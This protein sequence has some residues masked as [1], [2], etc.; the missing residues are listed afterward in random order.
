MSE[1]RSVLH[2]RVGM[3]NSPARLLAAVNAILYEDLSR[4]ELLNSMFYARLDLEKRTL[5]FANAG[6]T[7][8][9]LFRS[10]N[11]TFEELDAEGMLMGVKRE[12]LFEEKELGVADGD[13]LLLYTDGITESENVMGEFFGAGRLNETVRKH[14]GCAPE[15]IIAAVFGEVSAFSGGKNHADDMTMVVI[16]IGSAG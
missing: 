1:A 4:A 2:A 16:R 7:R 6:H 14:A 9:L 15:E 10:G 13:I 5:L 8:S 11:G 3:E 12:V